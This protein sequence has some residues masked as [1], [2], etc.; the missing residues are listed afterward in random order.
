[1]S[2]ELEEVPLE[3]KNKIQG[4]GYAHIAAGVIN[5]LLAFLWGISGVMGILYVVGVV[6]CCPAILLFP[7]GLYELYVGWQ[8]LQSDH[9]QLRAPRVAAYADFTALLGFSVL[10]A[11]MG[12][13]TLMMLNDPKVKAYYEARGGY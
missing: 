5:L 2:T 3:V 8:H 10:S 4:I 9:S 1:M 7:I 11:A 12:A 6:F 13:M